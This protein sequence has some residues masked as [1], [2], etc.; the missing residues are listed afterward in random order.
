[1]EKAVLSKNEIESKQN[2]LI[3]EGVFLFAKIWM[4]VYMS[5]RKLVWNED[6]FKRYQSEGR[7]KGAGADYK[8]WLD[9]QSFPSE[10]RASRLLGVKTGRV[11][12]FFSDTQRKY[13]LM[14]D[15]LD[16]SV[17]DIRE[18]QPLLDLVKVVNDD[19]LDLR[20][21]QDENKHYVL[22]TTFLISKR[23]P[24]G[25]IMEFARSI[26]YASNL[27]KKSTLES[28]EVQRR[29]FEKKGIDFGIVTNKDLN[30]VQVKNIEW[31]NPITA[32]S[33]K[34]ENISDIEMIIKS[35]YQSE[36]IT[37]NELL[38]SID[39]D[40][41]LEVGTAIQVFKSMVANRKVVIDFLHPI[42]L[43]TK[44]DIFF[45]EEVENDISESNIQR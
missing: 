16:E 25:E 42:N 40:Y 34:H 17:I 6:K 28:L 2:I 12:H 30:M 32:M 19:D 22:T 11:H 45:K 29:Y 36:N 27:D 14:L 3:I 13:F 7:G 23:M 43:R 21:Y 4:E 24:N 37:F 26:K 44:I 1:M 18:H 38:E 35:R 5:K 20:K 33:F 31:L 8:P 41:G 39:N 10:G 9:T 15:W